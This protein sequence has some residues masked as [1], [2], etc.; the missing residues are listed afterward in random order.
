MRFTTESML[1]AIAIALDEI[2]QKKF[3]H[4]RYQK[5]FYRQLTKLQR[6]LRH[7]RIPRCALLPPSGS[8]W[9][10]VFLSGCDQALITL[11]GLDF[12]T[13]HYIET[14]FKPFYDTLTPFSND[15]TIVELRKETGR[16]RQMSSSDG[17]GLVLTWTRTRGSTMVLQLIF[18][19]T[20][21]SI[22]TYLTFCTHILIHVLQGIDDARVRRPSVEKIREY[23]EAVS[24]RHP[25]LNDVWCT[26]DGIKLMLECAADEDVQNRF[27]NGWTCDH[28][29]GAVLVFCPDGTILICCYN[30][31]GTVHDS[32]IALM[33]DIYK[34]L[35]AVYNLTGGKCTVDSAFAR[36]TYPFLIKSCKPSLDMTIEAME[37]ARD[38]TSMRQSS[39]WGMRAFQSS[40]P[41]IK[42]RISIEYRGQRK[43]TMKLLI[44]LYNLRTRKIGINQILNVYM[45]SLTEDVNA[46]YIN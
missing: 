33:G 16:P 42:D 29:I 4:S 37:I 12:E 43:L 44:L 25:F 26:M 28:Y 38:A 20:E 46:L 23:Q 27:Y 31:P 24:R 30:V 8:A 6:H 45:P 34:K 13:F 35:E 17:L 22:S 11:T 2:E 15:G 3:V 14:R 40:F 32:N 5:R 9:R 21:T 41:R 39:E 36:N 1:M 19:M 18:G 10:R 7:R